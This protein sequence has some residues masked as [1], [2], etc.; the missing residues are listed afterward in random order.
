MVPLLRKEAFQNRVLPLSVKAWHGMIAQ[1]TAP[2]RSELIRGVIVEKMPKSILHIKLVCR[3][4]L[5][6]Q[7]AITAGA[8]IRQEAPLTLADSEPEPDLSVVEG[9]EEDY[10]SHP[11][12]AKLVI[13]VSVSTLEEDREMA[14]IYAEA[15]VD[16]Y[17]IVNAQQRCLEV[18]R[19]P[20]EGVYTKL[21]KFGA[22]ETAR[23]LSSSGFELDV[24]ALF[25]GLPD[26]ATK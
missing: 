17:W 18:H 21:E 14:A 12:T 16:E 23:S 8:W 22:G 26:L 10:Q 24:T 9:S 2:D 7:R 11:T 25:E 19:S 1:G 4:L 6:L 15:R 20:S 13:E 5:L 3:L